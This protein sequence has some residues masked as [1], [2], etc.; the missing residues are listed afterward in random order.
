M[1]RALLLCILSGGALLLRAQTTQGIVSGRVF[2]RA[3]NTGIQTASILCSNLETN[4]KRTIRSGSN[5][6]YAIPF[7]PPGRYRMEASAQDYQPQIL[8]SLDLQV[9]G[10]VELNF[11]L[12][13][14]AELKRGGLYGDVSLAGQLEVVNFFG[15]DVGFAAPLEVLEAQAGPLQP[16]ISY[17]IDADEINRLPLRSRDVYSLLATVPGATSDTVTAVSLF[18]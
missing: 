4:E 12:R 8:Q 9:A 6:T 11:P 16:S 18:C 7:L 14:L 2:D 3:S 17:V 10:R 15:P 1:S 5:G 13:S